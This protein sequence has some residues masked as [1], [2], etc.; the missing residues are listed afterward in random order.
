MHGQQAAGGR[1]RRERWKHVTLPHTSCYYSAAC[2]GLMTVPH[3]HNGWTHALSTVHAPFTSYAEGGAT[4]VYCNRAVCPSI[5]LSVTSISRH[6][7]KTK[8]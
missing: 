4:E 7:L 2:L 5:C 3:K 6:S 8:R 1:L